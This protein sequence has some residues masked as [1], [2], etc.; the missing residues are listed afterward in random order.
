LLVSSEKEKNASLQIEKKKK[1][2]EETEPS[3]I[4]RDNRRR[5]AS[6]TITTKPMDPR[7]VKKELLPLLEKLD[8][9]PGYS[10]EFDPE[11]IH[12]AQNL[13]S[14]LFFFFIAVIFCYMIM[15]CINESFTVPLI[16]LAA[17]PPSLSFP[18]IILAL[19]GSAYNLP[20]A[21]AFIAVSGMSVNA[22]ILC[23]DSIRLNIGC[24][25]ELTSLNIYHALRQKIP[26]LLATTCTTVAGAIPFLFLSE[27]ANILIRTIA[28]VSALGVAC[29]CIIS[30]TVIPSIFILSKETFRLFSRKN[31]LL[32]RNKNHD[33]GVKNDN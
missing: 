31:I 10:V 20:V 24:K 4:R 5:T 1:K 3:S 8:L 33:F 2:K 26:A 13:S 32:V 25:R 22:A 12:Q 6:I 29:S 7:R 18:A 14:T 16:V 15:S 27:G 23:I 17:I 9:P 11:A 28:L 21:C 30:I 19:S